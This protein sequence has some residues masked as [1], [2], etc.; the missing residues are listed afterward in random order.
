MKDLR[1]IL[2]VKSVQ[3][4]S[5]GFHTFDELYKHRMILFSIICNTAEY[6]QYAWKSKLHDD[7]TMFKDYFI[8]GIITPEGDFTYHY[9]LKY[10][11]EFNVKE[12]E[13][14]PKWDGHT[15]HDIVRLKSLLSN[16]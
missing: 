9:H 16:K 15:S 5:D 7:K 14:A 2:N 3:E 12:L 8:V 11:D 10:W 4:Y 1:K 13:T 6:N